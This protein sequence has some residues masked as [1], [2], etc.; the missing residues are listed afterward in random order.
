MGQNGTDQDL[1]FEQNIARLEEIIGRLEKGD[2]PLAE[3]LA[4][5]EEGVQIVR[6]CSGQL[7]V[8]ET[9]IAMLLTKGEGEDPEVVAF[10]HF[11]QKGV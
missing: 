10:D 2:V 11:E 4:L 5:F 8:A 7:D 9:R 1:T 6:R 3:S